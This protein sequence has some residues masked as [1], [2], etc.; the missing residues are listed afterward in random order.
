MTPDEFR[1]KLSEWQASRHYLPDFIMEYI[2]SLEKKAGEKKTVF[3]VRAIYQHDMGVEHRVIYQGTDADAAFRQCYSEIS[4]YIKDNKKNYGYPF[5]EYYFEKEY[6]NED[7]CEKDFTGLEIKKMFIDW[8]ESAIKNKQ[9]I[10]YDL[11][12]NDDWLGEDAEGEAGGFE[13]DI[14]EV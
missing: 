1:K 14:T 13:L 8:I 11:Q 6:P 12:H 10:S 4:N 2:E 5:D 9:N 3:T 7:I